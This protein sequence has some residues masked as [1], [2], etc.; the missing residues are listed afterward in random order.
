[1]SRKDSFQSTWKYKRI[2]VSQILFGMPV[3]KSNT[4]GLL[5]ENVSGTNI[6]KG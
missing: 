5:A 1:M 4:F 3:S 6:S 2:D